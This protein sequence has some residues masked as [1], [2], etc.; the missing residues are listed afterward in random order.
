MKWSEKAPRKGDII[1]TKVRFYH[2]YGIFV[3]EDTVVQFGLRDNTG[4][5]PDTIEV[6]I[7]DIN[8]FCGKNMVETA[9]LSLSEK[10]K[11]K[12]VR[13]TVQTAMSLIGT[14]GYNILHN[15]CEHFVNKCVFGQSSSKF[16]EDARKEIRSKLSNKKS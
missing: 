16:L 3:D 13:K 10:L 15:N 14:R 5:D 1:R 4:I 6:M 8:G 12:T 9:Q 2:H 11:R 7:T